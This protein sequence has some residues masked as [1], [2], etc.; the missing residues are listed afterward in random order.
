MSRNGYTDPKPTPKPWPACKRNMRH[1]W[2]VWDLEA[3]G[4]RWRYCVR[5]CGALE[6]LED[7]AGFPAIWRRARPIA[8]PREYRGTP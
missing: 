7:R 8:M 4:F 6:V 3:G 1:R 2:S 5:H